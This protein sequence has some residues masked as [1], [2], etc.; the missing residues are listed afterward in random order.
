MGSGSRIRLNRYAFHGTAEHAGRMDWQADTFDRLDRIGR[1]R[2]PMPNPHVAQ[3][4][5]CAYGKE[6]YG[7]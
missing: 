3:K 5:S 2:I 1:G 4:L 6:V 7:Q